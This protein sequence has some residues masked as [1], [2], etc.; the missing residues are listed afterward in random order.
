M[1]KI[2]DLK[3]GKGYFEL[4]LNK[5]ELKSIRTIVNSHYLENLKENYRLIQ[6]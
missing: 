5:M 2:S 1:N 6:Y 4:K 3:N